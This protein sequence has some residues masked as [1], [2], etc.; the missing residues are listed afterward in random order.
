MIT[1]IS[2][3]TRQAALMSGASIILAGI[4]LVSLRVLGHS[5]PSAQ[6]EALLLSLAFCVVACGLLFIRR[7]GQAHLALGM[8]L[9][10][11]GGATVVLLPL[12]LPG[13][14]GNDPDM[15]F[16]LLGPLYLFTGILLIAVSLL[17]HRHWMER[18]KTMWVRT[19]LLAGPAAVLSLL[20]PIALGPHLWDVPPYGFDLVA[21]SL[22]LGVGIF[23]AGSRFVTPV[24]SDAHQETVSGIAHEA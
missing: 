23:V 17:N 3:E 7:L 15:L 12:L 10:I 19:A 1:S 24:Q 20:I 5:W 14:G 18:S 8:Y 16:Q 2:K 21:A 9:L 11:I 6:F 22:V 13:Y 4:T